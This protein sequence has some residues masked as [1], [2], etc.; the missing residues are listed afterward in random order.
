MTKSLK[1][2]MVVLIAGLLLAFSQVW[3]RSGVTVWVFDIGQGDAIFIAAPNKQV[4]IDGGPDA[5][6]LERLS[7]VIPWWDRSIDLV[8]NTHPHEDHFLGLLPVFERYQVNEI[9]DSDQGYVTPEF[10]EY[11]RLAEQ[12]GQGRRGVSQGEVIDLGQ[13]ARLTVLWPLASYAGALLDDP[14][15]GSVVLLLEYGGQSMLLTGDAGME[16]ESAIIAALSNQ[17]EIL[18]VG[19]HGS[20]T[21]TGQELIDAIHPEVAIISLGADN[22]FGHPSSFVVQRLMSAGVKVYRTDLQG[23]VKIKLSTQGYFV[24]AQ[25]L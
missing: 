18:K 11:V 4:L 3:P 2:G 1:I 17:V 22:Q 12:E 10:S 20:D 13:G 14:N 24:K 8:I 16:E 25:P 5:L 19:H 9:L 23:S 6:V 7:A 21:S 15:D